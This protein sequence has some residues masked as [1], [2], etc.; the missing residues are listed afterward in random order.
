MV[1]DHGGRRVTIVPIYPLEVT[2]DELL[3][4]TLACAVEAKNLRALAVAAADDAIAG[5]S[6]E[7]SYVTMRPMQDVVRPYGQQVE[8]VL[9]VTQ[10]AELVSAELGRKVS[11]KS[12]RRWAQ[13]GQVP[14]VVLPSGHLG[15]LWSQVRPA[16]TRPVQVAS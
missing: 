8:P 16:L 10:T 11:G 1:T 3:E 15:F 13:K 14:A 2:R 7:G 9:T 12:V 4:L 6:P 5:D